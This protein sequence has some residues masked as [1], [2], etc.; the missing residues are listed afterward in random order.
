MT[1]HLQTDSRTELL[2]RIS[3]IWRGLFAVL[4]AGIAIA[5]WTGTLM[6]G[7]ALWQKILLT[8]CV[9]DRFNI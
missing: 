8:G 3:I 4:S 7:A 9:G 5:L 1:T 6:P 2:L